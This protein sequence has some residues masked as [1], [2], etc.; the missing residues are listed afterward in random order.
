MKN[1]KALIYAVALLILPIQSASGEMLVGKCI[2]VADGDTATVQT[3]HGER[4]IVRFQGIDAPENGQAYGREAR[5]KLISLILGKQIKIDQQG[6]DHYNRTLG[7]VYL[8]KRRIN[9]ELVAA[10]CAW[11]SDYHAPDDTELA[12]AQKIAKKYHK[13]LWQDEAPLPPWEWRKTKRNASGDK[14]EYRS[15]PADGKYWVSRSGKIHNKSC[16]AYGISRSGTYT[17]NPQGINC[18]ACGGTGR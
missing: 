9:T 6:I 5:E 12:T 13:G 18:K 4:I 17:N 10:G 8:G 7:Q 16:E 14:Q 3:H 15:T 1:L 11:H 2:A